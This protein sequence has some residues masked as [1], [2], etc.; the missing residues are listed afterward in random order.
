MDV[1]LLG[2]MEVAGD[3]GD[4]LPVPG[5]KLRALL[6]IL[7]L[8]GGDVVPTDH[9]IEALWQDDPP[10]GVTNALQRL[11]S[12]LRNA[13][14]G[15]DTVVMRPPGYALAI[16]ENDVDVHRFETAMGAA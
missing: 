9:L 3:D 6:A 7:A 12:K 11:V 5:A 13:L 16:R 14:G 15:A 2:T 1:H 4:P 10:A 8:G